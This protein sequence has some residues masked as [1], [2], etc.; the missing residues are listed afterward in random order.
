MFRALPGKFE[1][2]HTEL[3]KASWN[4]YNKVYVPTLIVQFE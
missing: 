2:F 1:E 3:E 4:A